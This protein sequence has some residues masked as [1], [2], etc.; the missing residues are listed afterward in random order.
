MIITNATWFFIHMLKNFHK[1]Y[2][3]RGDIRMSKKTPRCRYGAVVFNI[4]LD[5]KKKP[6]SNLDKSEQNLDKI[7][8]KTWTNLSK[9]LI[10][11]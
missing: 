6:K 7:F 2:Q 11:P 10:K 9:T 8:I 3:F 5:N 4:N 1:W